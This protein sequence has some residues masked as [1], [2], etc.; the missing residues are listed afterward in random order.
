MI[1]VITSH[2]YLVHNLHPDLFQRYFPRINNRDALAYP[3]L[4]RY[5][6]TIGPTH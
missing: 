6:T 2:S 3:L 4:L 5:D 1:A